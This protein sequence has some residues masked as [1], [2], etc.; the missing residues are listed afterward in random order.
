MSVLQKSH[1]KEHKSECDKDMETQEQSSMTD[2]ADMDIVKSW[3]IKEEGAFQAM[4]K[5]F[6]IEAALADCQAIN[7]F[8]TFELAYDPK[9]K[10]QF[11]IKRIHVKDDVVK[12]PQKAWFHASINIINPS[13]VHYLWMNTNL[14]TT[15]N[16][17]YRDAIRR[18]PHKI[19]DPSWRAIVAYMNSKRCVGFEEFK[20]LL[21]NLTDADV[22][23][24]EVKKATALKTCCDFCATKSK[25]L[26]ACSFCGAVTYCSKECQVVLLCF[27]MLYTLVCSCVYIISY[28]IISNRLRLGIPIRQCASPDGITSI[29]YSKDLLNAFHCTLC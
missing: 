18:F 6:Y 11:L 12:E 4:L 14:S 5:S 15:L 1:W 2:V 26:R 13:K 10:P 20:A 25:G 19:G 8:I 29:T 9:A 16:S 28:H 3:V 22:L 17:P 27:I 7:K 21:P 23:V 24:D